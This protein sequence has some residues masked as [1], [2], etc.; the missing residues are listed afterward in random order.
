MTP[1]FFSFSYVLTSQYK[2]ESKKGM[3]PMNQI[4]LTLIQ[5]GDGCLVAAIPSTE[6][7][8]LLL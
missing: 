8:R 7:K 1:A 4:L 5:G 3:T 2:I 6:Y